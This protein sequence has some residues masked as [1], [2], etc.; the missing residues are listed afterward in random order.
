MYHVKHLPYFAF[1]VLSCA[2]APAPESAPAAPTLPPLPPPYDQIHTYEHRAK[3]ARA[4]QYLGPSN[5]QE[6]AS[7]FGEQPQ[8]FC[9]ANPFPYGSYLVYESGKLQVMKPDLFHA[10][11]RRSQFDKEVAP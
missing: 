7:L 3:A 1:L 2:A 8:V 4:V 11:Y 6:I 5:C 10:L 9:T